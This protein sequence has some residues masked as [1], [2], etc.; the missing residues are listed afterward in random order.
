MPE[1]HLWHNIIERNFQSMLKMSYPGGVP[2]MQRECLRDAFFG[3]INAYR[4][5][6]LKLVDNNDKAL[7]A[8]AIAE[9]E[10]EMRAFVVHMKLRTQGKG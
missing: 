2:D 4:A 7:E 3:G 10:N 8:P 5:L 9:L 1:I 6:L